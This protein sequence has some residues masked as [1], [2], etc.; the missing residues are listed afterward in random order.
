MKK[1][2][3]I[4]ALLAGSLALAEQKKVEISP[5]IGYNIAEGNLNVKDDGYPVG[6]IELQ[7]N[8]ADSKWSPE[9]SLLYSQGV[10]YKSGTASK[11]KPGQD[12]KV[13]RGA[14]NGVYTF[15]ETS[16]VIPFAKLGAGLEKISNESHSMEDGFFVDAG[17]GAKVPF[18]ENLALKLEA[19]YMAKVGTN[20][21]GFADSNL[22][23]MAGLTFAFGETAQKAAP[24]SE[25]VVEEPVEAAPV[26]A[27]AAAPVVAAAVV[28]MDDDKDGVLND[29]D[30]CPST[31]TGVKVDAMGCELDD[32]KDGVVNS[33][34]NCPATEVGTKVDANGCS[35]DTDNDG[36][37]NA[38]DLCPN[39][40]VGAAVNSDG[41][42]HT[43]PLNVNFENNSDAIKPAS[44]A[45]IQKYADFLKQN[46][47]YSAK[48]IG[49]T[50][51]RGSAAYNQKL[52]QKRAAA[53]VSDLESKGAK[54]SQLSYEGKGEASPIADNATAEGRAQ[55]RRIEAELTRN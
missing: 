54:A 17:A 11:Y 46:S 15:D 8:T 36:V 49:Y 43:L 5:M 35:V 44:E 30:K 34:D 45:K 37:L 53:V 9:F 38:N 6:G 50:D 16:S 19:I 41:C 7:F 39:T 24:A 25:P 12:T 3:L 27:V 51:S 48:I 33:K 31:L 26:A 28:V 55:N 18:T 47:N 10:D 1:L 21:A 32:D 13:V 29:A 23:V 4:P 22:I 52:S 14:F 42:P 40:V 2:L 20:N